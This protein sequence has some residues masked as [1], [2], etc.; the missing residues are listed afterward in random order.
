MQK[1]KAKTATVNTLAL[2]VGG[3]VIGLPVAIGLGGMLILTVFSLLLILGAGLVSGLTPILTIII[4]ICVVTLFMLIR[5]TLK[6]SGG[7]R[8]LLQRLRGIQEEQARVERLV[9]KD[10]AQLSDSAENMLYSEE[11]SVHQQKKR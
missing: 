4:G 2:R 1:D 7:I 11:N 9:Q 3:L 10:N 6:Y 8:A 5:A